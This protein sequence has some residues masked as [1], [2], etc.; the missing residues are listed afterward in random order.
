V[1][2]EGVIRGCKDSVLSRWSYAH[3]WI[4]FYDRRNTEV[5]LMAPVNLVGIQ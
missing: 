4:P 5:V 3:L 1:G 2:E